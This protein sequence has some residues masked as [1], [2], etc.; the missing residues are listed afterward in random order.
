MKPE[1][2][3]AHLMKLQQQLGVAPGLC[4]VEAFPKSV[5]DQ[6]QVKTILRTFAPDQG[7]LCFQ[8]RVD[9]FLPG[10][11]LPD[12]GILLNGEVTAPSGESLHIR[13]DGDGSWV[14]TRFVEQAPDERGATHLVE[15]VTFLGEP[16]ARFEPTQDLCYRRYWG[17]DPDFG[18]RPVLA[19]F[20]GFKG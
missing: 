14:L 6:T 12:Q 10:E 8:S 3:R 5:A 15:E 4:R 7:W 9:R 20:V 18:Y 16:L 2:L 1:T 17:Y 19:R 11:D 13:Q